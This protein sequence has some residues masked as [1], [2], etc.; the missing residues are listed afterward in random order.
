MA[1][2]ANTEHTW[3]FIH[4][5]HGVGRIRLTPDTF[6]VYLLAIGSLRKFGSPNLSAIS[7]QDVE[8]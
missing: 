6:S 4:R 7:D 5:S 8:K 2:S 1:L 3:D